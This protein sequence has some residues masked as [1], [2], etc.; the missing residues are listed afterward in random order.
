M[1]SISCKI[2]FVL[3]LQVLQ[4]YI[5]ALRRRMER[6]LDVLGRRMFDGFRDERPTAFVRGWV[7]LRL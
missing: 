4:N 3:Q 7:Q 1:P 2:N 5:G 6:R